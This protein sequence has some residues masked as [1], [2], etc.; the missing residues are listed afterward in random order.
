MMC[1]VFLLRFGV[2]SVWVRFWCCWKW[3]LLIG[4][5]SILNIM[6]NWL[7]LMVWWCVIICLRKVGLICF[8]ICWCI[9]W[10]VNS[11]WLISCLVFVLCM[12]SWLWSL[13]WFMMCSMWLWNVLV[14]WF[15]K[16]SVLICCL[17]LMCICSVFCVVCCVIDVLRLVYW[18]VLDCG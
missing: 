12:I 8:C 18:F 15:G 16:C 7:M 1:V 13:I 11:C 9:L 14:R 6:M 17:I 10:L 5:L 2:S 3:L 4:L